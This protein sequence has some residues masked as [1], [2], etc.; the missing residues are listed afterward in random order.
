MV[1][2]PP[3]LPSS[4]PI[5]LFFP[6]PI[7]NPKFIKDPLS[8]PKVPNLEYLSWYQQDQLA[9]SYPMSIIFECYFILLL[10]VLRLMLY[11]IVFKYIFL[12]LL[13]QMKLLLSPLGFIQR[14]QEDFKGTT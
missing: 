9:I 13:L 12:R 4:P 3:P 5:P 7:A 8:P 2:L 10:V 6:P 14:L 1:H 11:G